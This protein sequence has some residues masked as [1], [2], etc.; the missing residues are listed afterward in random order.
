MRVSKPVY[1]TD[2]LQLQQLLH[3]IKM[4]TNLRGG[5]VAAAAVAVDTDLILDICML[6][7]NEA[8]ADFFG[9]FPICY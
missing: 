2:E 8:L 4:D 5:P 3:N 7:T 6:Y 9:R 1:P